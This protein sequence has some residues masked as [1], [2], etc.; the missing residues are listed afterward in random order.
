MQV[1][2]DGIKTST[3]R[4][5]IFRICFVRETWESQTREY[6]EKLGLQC[7]LADTNFLFPAQHR[8]WECGPLLQY[9]REVSE[10]G[11]LS[12][13]S[14]ASAQWRETLQMQCVPSDFHYQWQHAQ[15]SLRFQTQLFAFCY[16]EPRCVPKVEDFEWHARIDLVL[17]G[18]CIAQRLHDTA[19]I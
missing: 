2:K 8:Q 1:S 10:L 19:H 11:Q 12:G 3:N 14:H 9:L 13:S 17:T 5:S 16:Q 7:Q 15:V 4:P 6:I 18:D